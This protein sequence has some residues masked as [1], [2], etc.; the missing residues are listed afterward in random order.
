MSGAAQ[1]SDIGTVRV[2][3][4]ERE[5][6]VGRVRFLQSHADEG[7]AGVTKFPLRQRRF[8]LRFSSLAVENSLAPSNCP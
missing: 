6:D 7:K 4:E 3:P 1:G 5:A 2:R 8:T